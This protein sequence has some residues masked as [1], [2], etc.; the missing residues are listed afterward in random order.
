MAITTTKHV[1]ESNV[2]GTAQDFTMGHDARVVLVKINRAGDPAV[3]VLED[4]AS[5]QV[6]RRFAAFSTGAELPPNFVHVGSACDG[7]STFHV[8]ELVTTN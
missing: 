6:T 7:A 5:E 8:G 4:N 1:F 2:S 3:Y